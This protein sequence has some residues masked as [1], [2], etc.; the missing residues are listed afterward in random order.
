MGLQEDMVRTLNG[1]LAQALAD[2]ATAE[3][4]REKVAGSN[5][6]LASTVKSL[7]QEL[8]SVKQ[9]VASLNE[10]VASLQATLA[11]ERATSASSLEVAQ[12]DLEAVRERAKKL[13]QE[14]WRNAEVQLAA[15]GRVHD[16]QRELQVAQEARGKA[17]AS[18]HAAQEACGQAEASLADAQDRSSSLSDQLAAERARREAAEAA[19]AEQQAGFSMEQDAC[20]L[21]TSPSPRDGLLSRMPSSA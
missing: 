12:A 8:A 19:L 17:E 3:R 6:L 13:D 15:S 1:A 18:L 2:T 9:E 5:Q 10:E 7:Q 4:E 14:L 21:Y 11:T 16:L 20:L